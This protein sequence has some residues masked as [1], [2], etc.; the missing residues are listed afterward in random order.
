MHPAI[1]TQADFLGDEASLEAGTAQGDSPSLT[2]QEDAAD[3]DINILL[4][5]YGVTPHKKQEVFGPVDYDLDLQT[6]LNAIESAGNAWHGLP[7]ALKD[8]Y[9]GWPQLLAA[10]HSGELKL[11]AE[12]GVLEEHPSPLTPKP[13]ETNVTPPKPEA[14]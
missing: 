6:A 11:N 14:Q 2:R 4:A 12:K 9:K 1:R 13:P 3:A 5:R 10:L 7:K 8:K